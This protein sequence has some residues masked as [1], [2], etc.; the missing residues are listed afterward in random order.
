M[1]LKLVQFVLGVATLAA[2]SVSGAHHSFAMFKMGEDVTLAGTVKEFQWTNPHCWVQVLVPRK[3]GGVDEWGI[4]TLSP[5]LLKKSGWTRHSI[6]PGDKV[7]FVIHPLKDGKLGGSLESVTFADGHQ[8][9][10]KPPPPAAS[11]AEKSGS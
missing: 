10:L 8:L 5:Y 6:Q 11:A 4:E 2:A 3:D 1:K 9:V 7:T